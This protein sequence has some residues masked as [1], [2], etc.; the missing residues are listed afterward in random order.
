M[1]LGSQLAAQ[2]V[3]ARSRGQ[4]TSRSRNRAATLAGA[5]SWPVTAA[6]GSPAR[7]T[8]PV[9]TPT[10]V[11]QRAAEMEACPATMARSAETLA[12]GAGWA[13]PGLLSSSDIRASFRLPQP[14]RRLP[15]AR[16]AVVEEWVEARADDR[17]CVIEGWR[18]RKQ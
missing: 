14:P 12:F 2:A 4:L 1:S 18:D 5:V 9:A 11:D 3:Q 15:S 7:A 6:S 13:G 10:T 17:Q 16:C 8:A